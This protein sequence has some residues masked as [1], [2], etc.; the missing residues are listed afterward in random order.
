MGL[1]LSIAQSIAQ[2]HGGK[3]SVQ[4]RLGEGS[5]FML[6]LPLAPEANHQNHP[7][8]EAVAV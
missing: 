2:A 3:I 8:A 1:G 5:T 4:S 6:W 7:E